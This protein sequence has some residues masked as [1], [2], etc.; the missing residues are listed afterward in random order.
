SQLNDRLD[1]V[2][3]FIENHSLSK[4]TVIFT[5]DPCLTYIL[6]KTGRSKSHSWTVVSCHRDCVEGNLDNLGPSNRPDLIFVVRSYLYFT[7]GRELLLKQALAE[8]ESGII[9]PETMRCSRDKDFELKQKMA[10]FMKG[11]QPPPEYRFDLIF[12]SARNDFEWSSVKR[13]FERLQV[14]DYK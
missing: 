5:Y 14:D 9:N 8:V 6:D 7:R 13:L 11:S 10:R 2:T 3:E 12:G 4:K 1:E